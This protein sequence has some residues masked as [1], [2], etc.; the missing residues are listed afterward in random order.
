[1]EFKELLRKI[2]FIDLLKGLKLTFSYILGAAARRRDALYTAP[3]QQ[4]GNRRDSLHRLQPVF[5]GLP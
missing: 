3:Q 4:P 5:A 1:M 2:F